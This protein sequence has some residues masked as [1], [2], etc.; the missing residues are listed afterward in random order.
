MS[1]NPKT[2]YYLGKEKKKRGGKIPSKAWYLDN[3]QVIFCFYC[4]QSNEKVRRAV[5][6]GVWVS[7][8]STGLSTAGCSR[9][10]TSSFK[11]SQLVTAVAA[12][13]PTTASSPGQGQ[14]PGSCFPCPAPQLGLQGREK[15]HTRLLPQRSSCRVP[16]GI[17]SW[18]LWRT[19]YSQFIINL[20][21]AIS[22]RARVCCAGCRTIICLSKCS[23]QVM[24]VPI[25]VLLD[26]L[27]KLHL[28]GDLG[29]VGISSTFRVRPNR[30][31]NRAFLPHNQMSRFFF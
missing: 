14:S 20:P 10:D 29:H 2:R 30:A 9:T 1:K 8:F 24:G 28:W 3:Q 4:L 15:S 11:V 5:S 12:Q 16:V 6:V 22:R 31:H 18:T 23:W 21:S 27:G 7:C 26:S 17:S 25:V 19:V 13:M